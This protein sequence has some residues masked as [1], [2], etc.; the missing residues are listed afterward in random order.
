MPRKRKVGRPRKRQHG[1]G[2][3]EVAKKIHDYVK[4]HRIIS[5]VAGIAGSLGV[6]HAGTIGSIAH[7]AGYGRKRRRRRM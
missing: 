2:I 5:R 6:P 1:K 3:K 7:T 4:K